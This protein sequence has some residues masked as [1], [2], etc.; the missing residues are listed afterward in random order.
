[1]K[2]VKS[3][4]DEKRIYFLTEYVHGMDLFD[5]LRAMGLLNNNESL[6]Y[7]G[8]LV[9]IMDFLHERSII[10]RDLKPEN[11]MVDSQGYLKLIDFGTAKIV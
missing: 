11:I 4:K 3:A 8:S 7:I 6:F 5:V 10:Y 2:L 9:L 1:M